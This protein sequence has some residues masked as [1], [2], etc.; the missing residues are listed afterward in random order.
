[1]KTTI[2]TKENKTEGT[3]FRFGSALVMKN[4]YFFL[5]VAFLGMIYINNAQRG[6]RKLM[7]INKIEKKV[8]EKR[9][10]YMSLKKDLMEQTSPS[11]L[12]RDLDGDVVF[13][14]KGPRILR[15]PKS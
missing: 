12:A 5:F 6:G 13:P 3:K 7:T 14:E 11:N 10:E 1:M 9:W 8:Q 15:A 4:M 2:K